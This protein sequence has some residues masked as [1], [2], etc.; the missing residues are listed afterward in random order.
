MVQPHFLR[1][2][3]IV[4]LRQCDVAAAHHLVER[5]DAALARAAL[6]RG[7]PRGLVAG[8]AGLQVVHVVAS[9][10]RTRE[11]HLEADGAVEVVVRRRR[12]P[13]DVGERNRP[14]HF[15]ARLV[16]PA[17]LQRLA[18]E[19]E[20]A[21]VPRR[22][23]EVVRALL[24]QP[25]FALRKYNIYLVEDDDVKHTLKENNNDLFSSSSFKCAS[26]APENC[27]SSARFWGHSSKRFL[28][29]R[30]PRPFST[31]LLPE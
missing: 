5:A 3:R 19:H 6:Q 25:P 16:R 29:Y 8:V 30:S 7:E 27:T 14:E 9:V 4:R 18:R 17:V 11:V 15:G 24:L 1:K 10:D 2:D 13:A 23:E 26:I 31:H 20:P 22:P 12:E 28:R 21:A